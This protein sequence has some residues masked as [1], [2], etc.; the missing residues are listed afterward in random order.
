MTIG[1]ELAQK[2][3]HFAASQELLSVTDK[4]FPDFQSLDSNAAEQVKAFCSKARLA[5]F[6]GHEYWQQLISKGIAGTIKP[7]QFLD[8][9]ENISYPSLQGRA[10]TDPRLLFDPTEFLPYATQLANP[11]F[12]AARTTHLHR[13]SLDLTLGDDSTVN[14]MTW[15]FLKM[16]R[17][18]LFSSWD[19]FIKQSITPSCN[20]AT[21]TPIVAKKPEALGKLTALLDGLKA[22]D[23]DELETQKTLS[24]N[25]AAGI[26]NYYLDKTTAKQSAALKKPAR[27]SALK[28]LA[29]FIPLLKYCIENIK[30]D[31]LQ[32][33][34]ALHI[35]DH[36]TQPAEADDKDKT[37][38]FTPVSS[39]TLQQHKQG[40]RIR[41]RYYASIF[42]PT[43]GP[44]DP[45]KTVFTFPQEPGHIAIISK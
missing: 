41:T 30:A 44:Q 39:N 27:C 29:Y 42:P 18:L 23:I 19:H 24:H 33:D 45:D 32:A 25:S 38:K 20:P 37:I 2:S 21:E 8:A 31:F 7:W 15:R 9:T 11:T 16:I 10:E 13:P 14:M 36:L 22:D 35:S 1:A 28:K 12:N 6:T 26:I 3:T 17:T 43:P 4:L 34:Q 5:D 40:T